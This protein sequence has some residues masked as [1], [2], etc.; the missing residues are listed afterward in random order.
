MR[1]GRPVFV[2]ALALVTVAV[3]ATHSSAR[4]KGPG[5]KQQKQHKLHVFH[6]RALHVH[7]NKKH[8]HHGTI[9]VKHHRHFEDRAGDQTDINVEKVFHV[10]QHTTFERV[11]VFGRG[12]NA[13]RK[14]HKAPFHDVHRGQHVI[15]HYRG[16]HATDVKIIH[17]HKAK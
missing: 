14:V 11:D 2:L 4:G 17:H 10:N 1:Y 15:V 6:G 7:H 5:K 13:I 12:Q 9:K 3:S 8:R 16:H